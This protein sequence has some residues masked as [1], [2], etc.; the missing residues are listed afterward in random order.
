VPDEDVWVPDLRGDPGTVPPSR[1]AGREWTFDDHATRDVPAV[2]DGVL[3][4]TARETVGWVGHSMGG[5]LLYTTLTLRPEAIAAGVAV[6][7]P[8]TL[9]EL[10]PLERVGAKVAR[11]FVAGPG[12]LPVRAMGRLSLALGVRRN[13]LVRQL[14]E[15]DDVDPGLVSGLARLALADIPR[16][17]ARQ[18]LAWART[19]TITD[20]GGAPWVRPSAVPLLVMGA[21]R[22]QVVPEPD[23]AAACAVHTDC[24]Y[25]RLGTSDGFSTEFGHIDPVLGRRS[26][27]EVYPVIAAFLDERLR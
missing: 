18:V 16:P 13:P 7:S 4:A 1:R 5:M 2:L 22:D 23:A 11:P 3:A 27:S 6:C 20:A 14:A 21:S 26:R 24:T 10:S 25:R 8:A 17:M 15:V 12:R 9:T 19:G